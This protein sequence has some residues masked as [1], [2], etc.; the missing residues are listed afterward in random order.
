[1]KSKMRVHES[2]ETID[3]H[4]LSFVDKHGIASVSISQSV[5]CIYQKGDLDLLIIDVFNHHKYFY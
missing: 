2:E 5:S 4:K 3:S 1:M